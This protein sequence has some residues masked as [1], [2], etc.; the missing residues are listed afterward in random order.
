MSTGSTAVRGSREATRTMRARL[1]APP[2]VQI[3]A[4]PKA[5]TATGQTSPSPSQSPPSRSSSSKPATTNATAI[6]RFPSHAAGSVVGR[7]PAPSPPALDPGSAA[8]N[9]ENRYSRRPA[10]PANARTTNASRMTTGST[11]SRSPHPPAT[12]ATTRSVALRVRRAWR[13]AW[14]G[15]EVWSM[16]PLPSDRCAVRRR[17]PFVSGVGSMLS[18]GGRAGHRGIPGGPRPVSGFPEGHPRWRA[19]SEDLI[20]DA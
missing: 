16:E 19:S 7:S 2:R 17:G 9:Q 3:T 6:A 12:P 11:P 5:A 1:A 10:P 8:I 18:H 20:I 14:R 15:V 4:E 13:R